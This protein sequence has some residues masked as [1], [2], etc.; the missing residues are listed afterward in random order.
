MAML[1]WELNMGVAGSGTPDQADVAGAAKP[2]K[3]VAQKRPYGSG[4]GYKYIVKGWSWA[5]SCFSA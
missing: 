5:I 2:S 4:Y 3:T 1:G